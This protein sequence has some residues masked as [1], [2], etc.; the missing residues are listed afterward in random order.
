VIWCVLDRAMHGVPASAGWLVLLFVVNGCGSPTTV[1]PAAGKVVIGGKP[2]ANVPIQF[3]P[4]DEK[5]LPA[6][7]VTD[8]NGAFVLSTY[9]HGE[10]AMVGSY[11]AF[12]TVYPQSTDVP[13]AYRDSSTTPLQVEIPAGGKTDIVLTLK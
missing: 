11:K 10:G 13:Q 5:L 12:F 3:N 6:N 7:G 8:G 9:P 2:L 4:L 1:V